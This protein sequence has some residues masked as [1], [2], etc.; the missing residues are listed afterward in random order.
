MTE[1][2]N[3][4]SQMR[5]KYTDACKCLDAFEGFVIHR[6]W[7]SYGNGN[8][9]LWAI[10]DRND[11]LFK[12]YWDRDSKSFF[13][14]LDVGGSSPF[15]LS[16]YEKTLKTKALTEGEHKYT[17]KVIRKRNGWVLDIL[18]TPGSWYLKTL[19]CNYPDNE[20]NTLSIQGNDWICVNPNELVI[21][22]MALIEGK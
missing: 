21:E 18:E 14:Q 4:I 22:A 10:L 15:R 2:K 6:L 9:T 7:E 1:F 20:S 16:S 11:M 3:F 8:M 17:V 12:V 5:S 13:E 19:L